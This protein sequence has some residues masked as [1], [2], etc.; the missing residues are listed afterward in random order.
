MTDWL[1]ERLRTNAC[2]CVCGWCHAANDYIFCCYCVF[3]SIDLKANV[4]TREILYCV[5]VFP[6]QFAWNIEILLRVWLSPLV[7]VAAVM[8]GSVS[9][10]ASFSNSSLPMMAPFIIVCC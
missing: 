1:T 4:K 7:V 9:V 6:M 10:R 3:N 2:V 8:D 5:C